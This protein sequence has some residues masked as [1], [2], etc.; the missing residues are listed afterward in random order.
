MCSRTASSMPRPRPPKF[1]LE[2]SSSSQPVLEEPIRFTRRRTYNTKKK[3]QVSNYMLCKA[4]CLNAGCGSRLENCVERIS[5]RPR[6]HDNKASSKAFS[7]PRPR[8]DH[9]EAKSK[10]MATKRCP[11]G[12]LE[13]EAVLENSTLSVTAVKCRKRSLARRHQHL[14][15][16]LF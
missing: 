3:Q 15:Q 12:V 2:E 5:L 16:S 13:F 9:F 1:V 10:A 14:P 8:P 6:L 7:R 11:R 4:Y